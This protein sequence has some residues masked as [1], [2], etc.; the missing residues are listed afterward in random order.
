MTCQHLPL[1]I[2]RGGLRLPRSTAFLAIAVAFA[3]GFSVAVWSIAL[4]IF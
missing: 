1:E 4:A 3:A 2:T